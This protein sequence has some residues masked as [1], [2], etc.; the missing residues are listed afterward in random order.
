MGIQSR[1]SAVSEEMIVRFEGGIKDLALGEAGFGEGTACCIR[2]TGARG[3]HGG[4]FIGEREPVDGDD[5]A[6]C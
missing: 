1:I 6:L 3:S 2:R 4:R 5:D